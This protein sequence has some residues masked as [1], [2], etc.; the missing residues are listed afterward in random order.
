MT[1]H[2]TKPATE[3]HPDHV[4]VDWMTREAYSRS[5]EP[6]RPDDETWGYYPEDEWHEAIDHLLRAGHGIRLTVAVLLSKAARHAADAEGVLH[7]WIEHEGNGFREYYV[8]DLD[9]P[10]TTDE[11]VEEARAELAKVPHDETT[12][13]AAHVRF[14]GMSDELVW[15]T[16]PVD[17]VYV[18]VSVGRAMQN[19]R[20]RI[21]DEIRGLKER[22]EATFKVGINDVYGWVGA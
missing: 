14:N 7:E 5:G 21:H 1:N 19:R 22:Y 6:T 11:D 20:D 13:L 2:A 3:R 10:Y 17:D 15:T 4:L 8:G 9:D 12:G 16:E 18:F